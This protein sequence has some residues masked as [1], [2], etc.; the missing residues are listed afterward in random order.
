MIVIAFLLAQP[1]LLALL[2]GASNKTKTFAPI[3]ALMALPLP[4]FLPAEWIL[5][6]ALAALA[7]TLYFIRAVE[8]SRRAGPMTFTKRLWCLT[9]TFDALGSEAAAPAI[10]PKEILAAVPWA[11]L[12]VASW[13][14]F[15]QTNQVA[16]AWVLG[17]VG[18]YATVE[19]LTRATEIFYRASGIAIPHV[20]MQ[21][22]LARSVSE[23]WGQRWNRPISNWL[24]TFCYQ[25]WARRS[26]P[27]TGMAAAFLASTMIHFYFI[28]TAL[29]LHAGIIMA[30]FF[31]LQIP[32]VLME[33]RLSVR[34]WPRVYARMWTVGV[35]VLASPLFV[36][37]MLRLLT[38]F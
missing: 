16:L 25:P 10:V 23:F 17:L 35:L 13:W 6:R 27:R 37:P 4:W 12:A 32:L 26:R 15:G 7:A 21:P 5:P 18:F 30:S 9:S 33:Q 2:L 28:W 34:H 20:Q 14:T 11:L 38:A 1:F 3:V 8:L 22:I 29:G 19:T 24:R 36:D 31:L